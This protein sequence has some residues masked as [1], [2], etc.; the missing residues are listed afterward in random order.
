MDNIHKL[1]ESYHRQIEL[2]RH[3]LNLPKFSFTTRL[4]V[5][6]CHIC[7]GSGLAREGEAQGI[8][9]KMV[10]KG[11]WWRFLSGQCK[12]LKG[13]AI[14]RFKTIYV[15]RLSWAEEMHN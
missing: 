14:F 5:H 15:Y 10:G 7:W 9:D 11:A 12:R 13:E 4:A 2:N 3:S 6:S 1:Y 8:K